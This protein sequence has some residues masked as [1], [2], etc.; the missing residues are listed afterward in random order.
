MNMKEQTPQ[1]SRFTKLV[2]IDPKQLGF[3]RKEKVL[4]GYSTLA[5]MLDAMINHFRKCPKK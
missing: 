5:G 2:R 3:V 1:S 4:A